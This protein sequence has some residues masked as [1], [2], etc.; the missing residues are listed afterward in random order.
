LT[1]SRIKEKIIK[2]A[3]AD[4]EKILQE[5]KLKAEGILQQ[6]KK[7]VQAIKAETE[8]I[9][10]ETKEKEIE[11]R[12]SAA[13]MKSRRA[14]LQEKRTIIDSV[15]DE[16]KKRL[17]DLKK[18][19]YIRF[20]ARLIKEEVKTEKATLVLSKDDVKKHG[21]GVGKKILKAIGAKETV[22]IE[23]GDFDGGC[24]VKR[25]TY[26]FNATLDTILARVK[27]KVESALQKTLFT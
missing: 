12:L 15:F 11:R 16:A 26:E 9:A 2:D 10:R 22:P 25:D 7:K 5:A 24:I 17:Q 18:A 8:E 4:A 27:E 23:K 13:R 21:N 19:E 20:I 3:K 1:D 14:I 6:S